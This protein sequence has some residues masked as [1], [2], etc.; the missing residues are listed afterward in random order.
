MAHLLTDSQLAELIA[1]AHEA[2]RWAYAPYSHYAVGA[3]LL[4][5]SGKIYRGVNVENA[6]YPLT[7][8]AERSALVSAVTEGEREFV[9]LAVATE[10]GGSPCGACRQMLAEFGLEVQVLIVNGQGEVVRRSTLRDL[11][12]DD[13]GAQNLPR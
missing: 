13:F 1:Q 12:P 10:N 2:R 11:L 6:V 4:A 7:L 9:A 5:T 3:A 8:C